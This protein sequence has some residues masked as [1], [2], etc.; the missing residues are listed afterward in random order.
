MIEIIL[1]IVFLFLGM[2]ETM[3]EEDS[4]GLGTDVG[5]ASGYADQGAGNQTASKTGSWETLVLFAVNF[6][7]LGVQM[8]MGNV[9]GNVV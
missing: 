7:R 3:S 6:T 8:N 4:S 2:G 5:K 9:M 1:N